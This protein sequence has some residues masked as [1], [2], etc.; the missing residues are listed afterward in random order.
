MPE[1]SCGS[2]AAGNE[3]DGGRGENAYEATIMEGMACPLVH[4]LPHYPS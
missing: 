2:N 1:L 4:C 3:P